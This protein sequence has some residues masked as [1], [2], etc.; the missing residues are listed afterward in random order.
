MKADLS[1]N[2]FDRAQHYSAV[3]LQQG[4]VVT[5]ADWNEQADIARYRTERLALDTIGSCGA[6]QAAPGYQLVAQTNALAVCAVNANVAWVVAEDG[7]LLVT[8]NGGAHWTLVD[9]ATSAHLRAIAQ[10]GN[11]GW[12]VGD[13]G[14]VRK[15]RD[16]GSS[17]TA[18]DS[19]TLRTLR[20]VA[21]VDA[22]RAWA[23]GA[24]R[25]VV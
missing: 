7:A 16:A 1:R 11:A 13:G 24:G 23:V 17:W 22:N 14:I 10:A 2:T 9:L 4:R 25:V 5:D 6:P 3:R 18:Q 8:S 19:G 12:I 20:G 15:T 21:A